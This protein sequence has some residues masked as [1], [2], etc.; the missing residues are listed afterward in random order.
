MIIE[1]YRFLKS[2]LKD[3]RKIE[4]L[5]LRFSKGIWIPKAFKNLGSRGFGVALWPSDRYWERA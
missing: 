1:F 4:R 5:V 3:P 2:T